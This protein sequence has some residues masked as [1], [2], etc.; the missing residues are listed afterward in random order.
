M[1]A[2]GITKGAKE[3]HHQ[4]ARRAGGVAPPWAAP[5]TLLTDS[6]VLSVP[7]LAPI[8]TPRRKP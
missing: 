4:S 2:S 8:F 5:G 3:G 7:P 1:E 6:W